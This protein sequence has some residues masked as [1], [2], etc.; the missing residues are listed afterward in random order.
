MKFPEETLKRMIEIVKKYQDD[1]LLDK[2]KQIQLFSDDSEK[3][4][5]FGYFQRIGEEK[6]YWTLGTIIGFVKT[7]KRRREHAL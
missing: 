7:E 3:N 2:L 1:K 4:R 6:G 5:W